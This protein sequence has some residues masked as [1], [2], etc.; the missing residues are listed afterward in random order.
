MMA[1]AS[2]HFAA[3]TPNIDYACELGEFARLQN[4][5]FEGIE[6]KDG[7]LELPQAPASACGCAGKISSGDT[8]K[9]GPSYFCVAQ[10]GA[11]LSVDKS[12]IPLRFIHLRFLAPDRPKFAS[13][14]LLWFH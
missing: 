5:P 9:S 4:D 13:Q 7:A 1:A 11:G 12:R 10:S 3:A 2:M 14:S 6:I 8:Q